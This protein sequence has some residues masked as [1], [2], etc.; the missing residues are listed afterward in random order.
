MRIGIVTH[1]SANNYGAML[2]CY[3]LQTAI[4]E[5]LPK[6]CVE[7][8][9]YRREQRW[10][11][12]TLSEIAHRKGG[13]GLYG[14]LKGAVHAFLAWRIIRKSADSKMQMFVDEMMKL[15]KHVTLSA[16]WR[17]SIP[18]EEDYDVLVVGSDQVWAHWT[19]RP[20]FMLETEHASKTCKVAYA[21]SFGNLSRLDEKDK[22][23]VRNKVKDFSSLSCREY[24]GA[25]L[26][27]SLTGQDCQVVVD[28][29]LLLR[30]EDW[31]NIAV[32]PQSAPDG[33]FV[34]SY[35]VGYSGLTNRLAKK[36]ARQLG[37]PC[38]IKRSVE[39]YTYFDEMGP[40]EFIW[41]IAHASYV[42]TMSFHG[43]VFS[44]LMGIPFYTVRTDAPQSRITTLLDMVGMRERLV[45]SFDAMD[46]S[47]PMP[48]ADEIS[49]RFFSMQQHSLNWL[50]K[51]LTGIEKA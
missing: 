7:V 45:D 24:D 36:A 10:T 42:I 39:P 51:A 12:L 3:A 32:K 1:Y 22:A 17:L 19:L 16:S 21:P 13:T 14:Y 4:Q 41:Y 25:R 49:N 30:K 28:P 8:L 26:L 34:F 31:L 35:Q 9:D 38:V 33:K 40:R 15:S 43:T 50:K 29:T 37:L 46:L 18:E 2:Q 23:Y 48:S 20:Y 5:L 44:L 47:A 11:R 6:A 27:E